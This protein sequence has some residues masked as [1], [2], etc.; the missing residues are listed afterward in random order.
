MNYNNIIKAL[1]AIGGQDQGDPFQRFLIYSPSADALTIPGTGRFK[2]NLGLLYNNQT[3]QLINNRGVLAD[4]IPIGPVVNRITSNVTLLD[5]INNIC[6]LTGRNFYVSMAQDSDGSNIVNIH[7]VHLIDTFAGNYSTLLNTYNGVSTDLSYGKELAN[8]ST[9]NLI[10]GDNVYYHS[11]AFKTLPFFGEYEHITP[12]GINVVGQPIY[13]RLDNKNRLIDPIGEISECGFWIYMDITKMNINLWNPISDAALLW[14]PIEKIYEYVRPIMNF[15]WISEA[16]L[17]AAQLGEKPF[18]LRA[19]ANDPGVRMLGSLTGFLQIMYPEIIN[20]TNQLMVD[21]GQLGAAP[22]LSIP[23][24]PDEL[25]ALAAFNNRIAGVILTYMNKFFNDEA[26]QKQFNDDMKTIHQFV[27]NLA[28]TYYGKKMLAISN[29]R[30]CANYANPELRSGQLKFS[31]EPTNEG[32]WVEY[33]NHVLGLADPY[34]GFFRNDTGRVGCLVKYSSTGDNGYFQDEV[35]P[36][37][38]PQNPT[39]SGILDVNQMD[40]DDYI[41]NANDIW[42]KAEVEDKT[43]F[44]TD[45]RGAVFPAYQITLNSPAYLKPKYF[46][47]NVTDQMLTIISLWNLAN[48]IGNGGVILT[49]PNYRVLDILLKAN[50]AGRNYRNGDLVIVEVVPHPNW[51]NGLDLKPP[52]N[53]VGYIVTGNRL[54]DGTTG[55]VERIYIRDGGDY[56]DDDGAINY[57]NKVTIQSATGEGLLIDSVE[58]GFAQDQVYC[59]LP[60][61]ISEFAPPNAG[62]VIIAN[63]NQNVGNQNVGQTDLNNIIGAHSNL[64]RDATPNAVAIPMKSNILTYGPYYSYNFANSFGKI[65]IEVDKDLAPWNYGSALL[66]YQA[67]VS[68]AQSAFDNNEVPLVI[69]ENG[70]TTIVGL[71]EYNL[72]DK[73]IIDGVAVGPHINSVNVTFGSQGITTSYDFKTFARKFGGLTNILNDQIKSITKNRQSQLQFIRNQQK[74]ALRISRKTGKGGVGRAQSVNYQSYI[75]ER[76]RNISHRAFIASIEPWEILD[77]EN[78]IYSDKITVVSEG[79]DKIPIEIERGYYKKAMMGFDG[80]FSPVSISGDAGLPRFAVPSGSGGS[81][82]PPY[83]T[84][85]FDD[86]CNSPDYSGVSGIIIDNRFL[87]PLSNPGSWHYHSGVAAGHSI[88]IV[89]G[90]DDVHPSGNFARSSHPQNDANKYDQDYRFIGLRGP[91]VLHQW[92][93]DTNGMPIPNEN[94]NA[95]DTRSGIFTSDTEPRFYQD[96]LQ[97]PSTWPV[98][99]IDLRFDRKRGVWVSPQGY[100]IIVAKTLEDIDPYGTGVAQVVTEDYSSSPS[101]SCSSN[102]EEYIY[103]WVLINVSQCAEDLTVLSSVSLT[104]SGLVFTTKAI[105]VLCYNDGGQIVIPVDYCGPTPTP[106]PTITLTPPPTPTPHSG[107]PEFPTPTPTSTLTVTPTVT[108]TSTVTPTPNDTEIK[109]IN[110]VDRIG[111]CHKSQTLIYAYYD[112]DSGEYIA[113]QEQDTA[114]TP[115]IY[116]NYEDVDFQAGRITVAGYAG[117]PCVGVSGYDIGDIVEVS[118]PLNLRSTCKQGVKGVAILFKTK[119]T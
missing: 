73:L 32:A 63:G 79:I 108:P 72:A 68:K 27:L 90:G 110:L 33:G 84:G 53:A 28:T 39:Y 86:V 97:K 12:D 45:S 103:N 23:P 4:G 82:E 71:P 10:F 62:P 47:G 91:L 16:D 13:P 93:Y 42:V 101:G 114:G 36:F 98:A 21:I 70:S 107:C 50:G 87:N 46:K 74:A 65:N 102:G 7:C 41:T 43:Y 22:A 31:S 52:R 18:N 56:F 59:A 96:W 99:P 115:T 80:L 3:D 48:G 109:Y 20:N 111:R 76:D 9:R 35:A 38:V 58:L 15:V 8:P 55:W 6:E 100:K 77:E 11:Y 95:D 78:K 24:T 66:M 85:T 105:K 104:N 14:D 92:G 26:R 57:V 54:P 1:L 29:E 89:A 51:G 34:L 106:T 2:V 67:G 61:T 19:F 112:T 81:F 117:N 118:N 113:L 116:G 44:I 30:I 83:Y 40:M 5:L 94:D 25:D 69:S 119:Q 75:P 37:P 17:W 60:Q 64:V 49:V 88:D